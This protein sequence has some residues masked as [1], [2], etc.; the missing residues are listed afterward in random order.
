ML[1]YENL[2]EWY[3]LEYREGHIDIIIHC[4]ATHLLSSCL[5]KAQRFEW[6]FID[7]WPRWGV[8]GCLQKEDG[9]DKSV[10]LSI[11]IPVVKKLKKEACTHCNGTGKDE[12]AYRGECMWCFGK[13][14]DHYYDY[15]VLEQISKTLTVLSECLH[16]YAFGK[17]KTDSS[18]KQILTFSTGF[19][20]GF[21][22]LCGI[23]SPHFADWIRS[24]GEFSPGERM[25]DVAKAM[26]STWKKMNG[27]KKNGSIYPH[28]E[29][30]F[31]VSAYDSGW[32][33]ITCPGDACGLHPASTYVD[34][35]GGYEFSCHNMDTPIQQLTLL[36][37]LAK[38]DMKCRE[39][40]HG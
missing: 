11:P 35:H 29:S 8:G 13:G 5:Q 17:E 15:R 34:N 33:N 31:W 14:R 6:E 12:D 39:E 23:Y 16:T 24:T 38:L 18:R 30:E 25:D 9:V 2:P 40:T 20:Q 27:F 32:L 1:S 3:R 36:A 28:T 7:G 4:S 22:P 19:R 21:Y 26:L 10:R 37:A